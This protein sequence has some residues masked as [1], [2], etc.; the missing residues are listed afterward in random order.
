VTNDIGQWLEG[1]GLGKYVRLFVDN[2]IDLDA[3]AYVTEDDLEKLGVALG[4]RRKIL[5]AVAQLAKEPIA[6]NDESSRPTAEIS[7]GAERRQLT[8]MF[9]DM[10]GSTALST[11]IDPED[12]RDA[13]RAYQDACA[14]VIA[15][16]DGYVARFMGDGVLAYFGWPRAHEDDAARA[17]N[18]GLGVIEAVGALSPPNGA[19]ERV[20]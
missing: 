4:A 3:L 8:V 7:T 10:V 1:I 20:W 16:F 6:K 9:C 2:E 15:R 12:Y 13:I 5:A 19:S 18:A 11:R 17:I 14:G